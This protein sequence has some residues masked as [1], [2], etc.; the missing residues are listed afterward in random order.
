[1]GVLGGALGDWKATRGLWMVRAALVG[2]VLSRAVLVVM[3][4]L[5]ALVYAR[6]VEAGGG[7]ASARV[8]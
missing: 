7:V 3:F 2:T 1:M 6:V 5:Q 8:C 4:L